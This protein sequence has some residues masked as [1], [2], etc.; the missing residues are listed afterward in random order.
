VIENANIIDKSHDSFFSC[1]ERNK[2]HDC[3]IEGNSISISEARKNHLNNHNN[4]TSNKNNNYNFNPLPNLITNYHNM[5]NDLLH[6]PY[7]QF[8]DQ[9]FYP[10]IIPYF[11]LFVNQN[12]DNQNLYNNISNFNAILNS[13]SF[14]NYNIV[15]NNKDIMSQT[16]MNFLSQFANQ[17]LSP[18][19]YTNHLINIK[20]A[21]SNDDNVDDNKKYENNKDLLKNNT[22]NIFNNL[23]N[24]KNEDQ[25]K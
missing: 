9:N 6:Y 18:D 7:Q 24:D 8:Y 15:N 20:R 2:M 13:Y 4:T 23:L 19:N 3:D 17:N 14:Q 12:L 10:N 21:R 11:N 22:T 1:N 16:Y 5:S 25:R